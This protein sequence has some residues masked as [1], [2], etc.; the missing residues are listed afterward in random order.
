[1]KLVNVCMLGK[2]SYY[3]VPKALDSIS[4]LSTFYTDGQMDNSNPL[5]RI[6]TRLLSSK[7]K[8]KVKDRKICLSNGGQIV[9]FNLFGILYALTRFIIISDK[10]EDFIYAL[11]NR[12]F[13]YL[14]L[15]NW[16]RAD[17]IYSYNSASSIIFTKKKT[18]CFLILEQTIVP[19]LEEINLLYDGKLKEVRLKKARRIIGAELQE[20]SL[21]N[22][23]V[24]PSNFVKDALLKYG[25]DDRKIKV[26]P[27]GVP[28]KY[29]YDRK[30][31]WNASE[32]LNILFV[33]EVGLR[34]GANYLIDAISKLIVKGLKIR[35]IL[36][37]KVSDNLLISNN[38]SS[39]I[40]VIGVVPNSEIRKYY[41]TAHIFALPSIAEGSA[42]AIYEGLCAGLPVITTDNAGSVVINGITGIIVPPKNV[43]ALM[44]AVECYYNNWD[45]Y[46]SHQNA[47]FQFRTELTEASYIARL[48]NF[49]FSVSTI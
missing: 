11:F 46:Q 7:F 23:I 36:V 16:R 28:E 14:V 26:I 47:V 1:M 8:N 10:T 25:V 31:I 22:A 29:L 12:T 24:V 45:I 2:R 19:K 43:S 27:Y 6:A 15:I 20:W 49:F 13:Q 4:F 5:M 18:K 39:Y 33:G 38:D 35:L 30:R 41:E 42:T 3:S 40:N 44:E 34:K 17:V 37:G 32:R 9:S 21:A 48:R